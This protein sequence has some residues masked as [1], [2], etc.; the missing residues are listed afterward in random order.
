MALKLLGMTFSCIGMFCAIACLG[1]GGS[2]QFGAAA[3]V[4]GV[5]FLLGLIGATLESADA[6]DMAPDFGPLAMSAN[7]LFGCGAVAGWLFGW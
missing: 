4:G 6:S 1:V 7:A 3:I 5:G 2:H